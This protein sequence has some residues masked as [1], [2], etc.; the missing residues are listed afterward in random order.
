M[1]GEDI[2]SEEAR[3]ATGAT[4]VGDGDEAPLALEERSGPARL[5]LPLP[6]LFSCSI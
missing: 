1:V 2:R 6:T 3:E 5:P 4:R